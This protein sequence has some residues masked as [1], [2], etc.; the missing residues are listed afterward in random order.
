LNASLHELREVRTEGIK[1]EGDR[2][3]ADIIRLIREECF[4]RDGARKLAEKKER[5][6]ALTKERDGLAK[7]VPQAASP[8]EARIQQALQARRNE[9]TALQQEVAAD[10][11]KLQKIKD[12]RS[13]IS[14][15]K[16]QMSRFAAE[17]EM[18]LKETGIPEA[19]HAPFRPAFPGD[20]ETPLTCR[21]STIERVVRTR[22]GTENPAEGTIRWLNGR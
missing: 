14:G 20:T 1:D 17:I 15:F 16:A 6:K 8:E 19:E 3:R 12:I 4:L 13:R 7:Q 11:Q 18:P 5:I 10:K 2:L 9:L 22:E 21:N